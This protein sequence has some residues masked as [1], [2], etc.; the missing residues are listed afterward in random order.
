MGVFDARRSDGGGFPV[1]GAQ[2]GCG[3]GGSGE[4][5]GGVG[6]LEEEVAREGKPLAS[7]TRLIWGYQHV[8]RAC[9]RCVCCVS[10]VGV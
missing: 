8:V 1:P 9:A 7:P 2:P 10:Q 5:G 4:G 3:A 6:G